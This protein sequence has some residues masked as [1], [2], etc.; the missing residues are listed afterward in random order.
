MAKLH[1]FCNFASD[2]DRIF[3]QRFTL[4]AKCGITIFTLLLFYLFWV[5]LAIIGIFVLII[6]VGLIERVV[7]TTY[8]FTT[9]EEGSFLVIDHGRFSSKTIVNVKDIVKCVPMKTNFG[10][11]H[12]LMVQ[13]VS[14]KILS[15]QP[16]DDESFMEELKKRQG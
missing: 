3:H 16:E 11:S 2:M 9:R 8:T 7:H 6:V 12:Y 1:N 14:G 10:T 5:K 4:A 13:H 15:V